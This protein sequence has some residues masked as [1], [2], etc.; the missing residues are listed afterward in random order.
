METTR[1]PSVYIISTGGTIA[2]KPVSQTQTTSYSAMDFDAN[3]LIDCIPGIR[4]RFSLDAEQVFTVG[5]SALTDSHLLQLS[6]RTN[7]LLAREDIDGIV[8]T[9][10]T[11]TMEETAFFLNLTVHSS[12][13]VV[14]TGSMRPTTVLSADGP[15][16]LLNAITVAAAPQSMGKGVIVCTNDQILPARDVTKT[17]TFRVDTFQCL[18]HGPLGSVFGSEVLYRYAPAA[19]HTLQSEFNVM[20]MTS[21]PRVE[22]VYTHI[23]CGDF[24][25]RAAMESGCDGIVL[26]GTGNG[27]LPPPIRDLCRSRGEDSPA[28][29]RASRVPGGYVGISGVVPDDIHRTIPSCGFSPQKSRILLQLALTKTKDLNALREIFSRY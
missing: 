9:H 24:M 17:S 18:E 21:L 28:I 2:A 22:I 5:S 11:D 27:S 15:L 12:K 19:P 6:R 4:E 14:L 10:G 3:D 8:I 20:D 7:E 26:A 13:P 23:S 29:V 16:N 1:K 25:L